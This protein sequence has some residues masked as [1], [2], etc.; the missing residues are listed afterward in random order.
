MVSGRPTSPLSHPH[1]NT[2]T[3]T[4]KAAPIDRMFIT[5]AFRGTNTDRNTIINSTND[6]RITA[7]MKMSSR[8]WM[9]CPRSMYP[10]V[11]P[12]TNTWALVSCS[13]GGRIWSRSRFT[14]VSVAADCGA[15]GGTTIT[16]AASPRGLSWGGATRTP[17]TRAAAAATA[18]AGPVTPG[19]GSATARTSGP[20]NPGPN[21][22]L[23]VS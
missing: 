6:S 22:R 11:I 2:A 7:P 4:P 21:P 5:A 8:L 23:M 20:L 9:R 12:P 19:R 18:S 14:R 13:A 15:D 17:G 3:I 16:T 1:W 10:A